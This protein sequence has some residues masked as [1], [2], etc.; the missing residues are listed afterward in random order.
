MWLIA[1]G[2][3]AWLW[4]SDD[5]TEAEEEV[6]FSYAANAAI[7]FG[8]LGYLAYACYYFTKQDIF[9]LLMQVFVPKPIVMPVF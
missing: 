2:Y 6:I 8:D 7:I 3:V 5:N 1:K 9:T 4:H